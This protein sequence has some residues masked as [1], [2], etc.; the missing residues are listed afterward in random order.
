[1]RV[2][3][4]TNVL[5]SALLTPAGVCRQ[6]IRWVPNRKFIIC[7][8]DRIRA[9]YETV[10]HRP[11]F[12]AFKEE[13]QE[14]LELVFWWAEEINTLPLPVVLPDPTELP[15]LEVALT[16]QAVLVTGNKRHFPEKL[17]R[18]VKIVSPRE[19]LDLLR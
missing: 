1:M 18:S 15:F 7:L 19:M 9:E 3:L 4:D 17:C 5:V 2:V 13:I 14:L 6:L 10:L 8:N 12:S 11:K 16:A